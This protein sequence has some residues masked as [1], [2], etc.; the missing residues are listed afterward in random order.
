MS[1]AF[2]DANVFLYALDTTHPLRAPCRKIVELIAAGRLTGESSVEVVQEFLHVRLRRSA[3]RSEALARAEEVVA[4][5]HQV[6]AFELRD[7]ERAFELA[8]RHP[9]LGA[10][11]AAHAATALNRGI[12]A[13]VSADRHFDGIPGL[14][15]V[16]PTDEASLAQLAG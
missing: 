10:R 14:E 5:C 16:D 4:I 15:R 8:Q 6:H 9:R 1:R 11:D 7:L 13:I 2:I 12:A 3:R